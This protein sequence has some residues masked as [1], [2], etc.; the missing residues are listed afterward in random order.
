M[1]TGDLKNHNIR[2]AVAVP[3]YGGMLSES[4]FHALLSLHQWCLTQGIEVK[5]NTIGN[6]SLI[7]RAR[8]TLVTMFLDDLTFIGTHLLFVDADIGFDNSN[9]ERLIRTDKDVACGIYPRKCIH[10]N[11]V[12]DAMKENPDISEEELSYKALG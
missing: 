11:Q 3:M 12:I 9:I 4:T 10:W 8:N 7:S 5:I 2:I 6:E 1:L